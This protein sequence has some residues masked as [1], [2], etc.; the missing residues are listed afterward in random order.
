MAGSGSRPVT[1][2]GSAVVSG[3]VTD[4]IHGQPVPGITV[5]IPGAASTVTD[6]AG[7]FALTAAGVRSLPLVVR[8][9]GFHT[10]E[11]HV[12]SSPLPAQIDVLPIGD[13]FDLDFFDHVFRFLGESH[14]ERW[15]VEP[16]FEIWTGVYE[17]VEGEFYGDFLASEE[18]APDRFAQIA[19][20]VIA[21]DAPKY[22]GGF[23]AGSNVV[24]IAPH[25]PGTRIGYSEYFKAFT[26]TVILVRGGD[27]SYGPSWAY[28]SGRIYAA[29]VWM[30]KR[31]H[32]DD[33]QVFS[34]ELAHTLGFHHPTGSQ[35]VPLPSIMRSADDVTSHDVLHGR[36]LYQRPPGSRTADVDPES[37]LVNAL[38]T[39]PEASRPDP[40][41]IRLVR[42]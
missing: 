7:A 10:R 13:D 3:V 14:T 12:A 37:F 23:L 30:Q 33:R 6:A 36:I 31:F 41:R 15:T 32:K 26:I 19:R 28:D 20:D 21:A 38:Q 9:D 2:L 40:S 1:D 24:E 11:T 22:T 42:D 17:R 16:R 4:A 8:G 27:A 34:H 35:N 5:E 18:V 39:E 25:P 29:S